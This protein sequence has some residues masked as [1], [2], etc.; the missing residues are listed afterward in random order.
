MIKTIAVA[1]R[2]P[3]MTHEEFIKYWHEEHAPLV[4][5]IWPGLKKYVQNEIIIEPGQKR[6]ADGI[7]EMW[8]DNPDAMKKAMA[9]VQSDAG[10]PIRDD[11]DNFCDLRPGS[12]GGFW[13][14]EE[15]VVKDELSKQ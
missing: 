12:G 11:A 14:V 1:R 10:K 3:D 8:Y 4:K 2:K 9:W 13:V 7:V 15:N 5:K 6:E